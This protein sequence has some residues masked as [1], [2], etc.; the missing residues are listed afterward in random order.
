MGANRHEVR[1]FMLGALKRCGSYKM[2]HQTLRQTVRELY[3]D[4]TGA[5]IDLEI[6]WL[7][8]KGYIDFVKQRLGDEKLWFL[9]DAGKALLTQDSE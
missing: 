7:A 2:P 3:E 8:A 1:L 5:E 9:T 6:Q 4:V